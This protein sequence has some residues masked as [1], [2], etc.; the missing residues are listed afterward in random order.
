MITSRTARASLLLGAFVSLTVGLALAQMPLAQTPPERVPLIMTKLPPQNSATYKSI[1]KHAGKARGQVL[2][3]TKTEMWEVPKE[4]VEA[5]KKAAANQGALATQLGNDWNHMFHSAPSDTKMNDKQMAMMERAKASRAT[6]GVGMMASPMAPMVEYA[7]TK[8]AGPNIGGPATSQEAA[9]VAI[10]LSDRTELTI[11]RT[12]VDIRKD[13]CV[14]RGAVEGTD[15]PA[16]IMWW[17]GGKMTGTL[18]HEGRLY[19]IRHMGGEMHAVVEMDGDRMPQE[20]APM[21]EGMRQNDPN[22]R[23]DP[24][25]NEGDASIMRPKRQQKGGQLR[26]KQAKAAK[27]TADQ[28]V[29]VVSPTDAATRKEPG[30]AGAPPKD[31]VID[32]IV[33]YTKKAASNYSDVKRELVDLS[34]EEA[35]ESFRQSGIGH[36]KLR[37]VHA[38]QTD[39]V[40][41]GSAHFDHVWRFADKGDGY[42]DEVHELR[43]KYKADVGVLIVDD[44]KGC[45]LATRV[46]ADAEEAFAVVH[47]ECAATSYTLAHEVGHLIGARHDLNL[48]KNMTPFPYGHGYVNGTKW[49][50]IMSYKESCGGCPR[51]PVWSS[52]FVKVKGEPAG[53]PDL[54]NARV[55]VEQAARVAAF[56]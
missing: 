17:P 35:N 26:G 43:N 45:G 8:D 12:S 7:L 6:M 15:A 37:L 54:D 14:W 29:A 9:R 33:A 34:I 13:M 22:L 4:N 53:T 19:S 16:T 51:L 2:T 31:V 52:P 25:R 32:L 21:P 48:D 10:K 56:R 50:D 5:V 18:Q 47:H 55:I 1:I 49:R 27:A 46:F 28:K 3:L 38:Y 23:D 40:E 36:V 44:P 41:E 11:V 30:K 39:Y 24:L 20:H 42:M